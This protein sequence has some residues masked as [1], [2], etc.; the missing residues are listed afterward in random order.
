MRL[1]LDFI[2][3]AIISVILIVSGILMNLIEPRWIIV[4]VLTSIVYGITSTII[5][6]RRMQFLA[7]ASVHSALLVSLMAIPI[8][9]MLG[10]DFRIYGVLMAIA[11]G[12]IL[13][14]IFDSIMRLGVDETIATS[15]FVAL[16]ASLSV[17]LMQY[18]LTRYS[19][20]VDVLAYILGDPMLVSWYDITLLTILSVIAISLA[21]L[22]LREQICLG[23]DRDSVRVSGL[24][25]TLYDMGFYL[26]LTIST[27]GFLR[28]VGFIIEHVLILMP[29]SIAVLISDTAYNAVIMSIAIAMI[30]SLVG[31]LLALYF[32]ISPS[33]LIGLILFTAYVSLALIKR[34]IERYS[35]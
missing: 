11:L 34:F 6:A 12:F 31:L 7:A 5:T 9:F 24:K 8:V 21:L 19:L 27:I 10:I 1:S 28:I 25:V 26:V 4:L 14:L 17:V 35:R 23:I 20:E 3:I 15:I 32:S 29:A 2:G 16:T 30:A 33:G 13:L 18:I 22:T